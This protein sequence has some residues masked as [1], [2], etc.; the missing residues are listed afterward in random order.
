MNIKQ[1]KPYSFWIV[2]GVLVLIE[3]GFLIFGARP[4]RPGIPRSRSSRP[5]TRSSRTSRT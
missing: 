3:I 2:V 4:T 1:L 5:S